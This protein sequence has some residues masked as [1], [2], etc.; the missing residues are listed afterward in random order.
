MYLS[1]LP[2]KAFKID[3]TF[4]QGALENTKDAI[5]VKTLVQLG[6]DLN[7]NVIAEGVE[8]EAHLKFLTDIGCPQAQGYLLCKPLTPFKMTLLLAEMI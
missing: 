2:V 3:K 5:I 4:I 1:R 8:V 6:K 7:L